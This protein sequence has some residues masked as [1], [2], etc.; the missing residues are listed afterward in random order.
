MPNGRMLTEHDRDDVF[1]T[2][3]PRG[4]YGMTIV[5][6]DTFAQACAWVGYTPDEVRAAQAASPYVTEVRS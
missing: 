1:T 5:E 3:K 2:A 6:H 4:E